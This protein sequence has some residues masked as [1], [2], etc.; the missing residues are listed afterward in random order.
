LH[1]VGARS[2]ESRSQS[3]DCSGGEASQN[4]KRKDGGID[5]DIFKARKICGA[6]CDQ[7]SNAGVGEADAENGSGCSDYQR[8]GQRL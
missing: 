4:G 5:G 3:E 2:A 6:D 7:F 1:Y 8:F